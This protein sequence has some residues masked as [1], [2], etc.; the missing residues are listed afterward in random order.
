[1]NQMTPITRKRKAKKDSLQE[2]FE[3]HVELVGVYDNAE[4]ITTSQKAQTKNPV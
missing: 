4:D 2:Q 3:K 1:M